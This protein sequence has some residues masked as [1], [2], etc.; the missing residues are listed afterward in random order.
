MPYGSALKLQEHEAKRCSFPLRL[1]V[2]GSGC[3]HNCSYCYARAQ[4]I[5][6]GWN[7][8]RNQ[9][10]PFPRIANM[11]CIKKTLSDLPEKKPECVSGSWKKIRPYLINKLPLR[12]GAVTDCFQRYM[13]EKTHSGLKLLRILNETK[14]PA[15]IVTKSDIIAEPDYIEAMKDNKDNLLLQLSI[16]SPSDKISC[17]IESGAPPTSYRLDALSKLVKE[18]FFTAVRINPLF[19][20]FPD[21]TLAKLADETNLRGVSLIKKARE[22]KVKTLPIFDFK[23]IS[24]ILS[25]FK[26]APPETKGK[27]TIIAG[28]VRLPFVCVKWVSEAIG[29]QPKELKEFFHLK[30]GNCYYFSS[31]EIRHYYEAISELCKKADIAFSICYD[32]DQNYNAFKDLWVNPRDCCNAVGVVKGFKKVFVDCC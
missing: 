29:W 23:L 21:K 15:Q 20:I 6:G 31:E 14:Y 9:K 5:V 2:Y 4:M 8:S 17:Q 7:N 25:V 26:K 10:H 3:D 16:T 28:F 27:H 13:E 19:P 24:D 30:Q 32:S 12:I 18:G 22:S 1:D 11:E